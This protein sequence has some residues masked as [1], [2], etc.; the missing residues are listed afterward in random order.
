MNYQLSIGSLQSI[1]P[2]IR[3]FLKHS[4][5]Q[6]RLFGYCQRTN[7]KNKIS[8]ETHGFHILRVL[9]MTFVVTL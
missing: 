7:T 1:M 6:I 9:H 5:K 2:K 8:T 4:M 3:L